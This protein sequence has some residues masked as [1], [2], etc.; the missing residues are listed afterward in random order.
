MNLIKHNPWNLV[1]FLVLYILWRRDQI[2]E[3]FIF[4]CL[5]VFRGFYTMTPRWL[6]VG[7]YSLQN[8]GGLGEEKKSFFRSLNV[9]V[10]FGKG[11]S[12][13]DLYWSS[14]LRQTLLI[15]ITL[16]SM[17]VVAHTLFVVNQGLHTFCGGRTWEYPGR[18]AHWLKAKA[19]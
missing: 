16:L 8:L 10:S 15:H 1:V 9:M 6:F 14:F 19:S 12:H 2:S 11:F 5:N 13:D 18:K 4:F 7:I 3:G 17:N